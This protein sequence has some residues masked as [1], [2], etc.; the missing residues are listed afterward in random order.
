[1]VSGEWCD[2]DAA[3]DAA[4]QAL[5]D[6]GIDGRGAAP[7][8]LGELLGAERLRGAAE[9]LEGGGLRGRQ[10]DRVGACDERHRFE[11]VDVAGTGLILG[12]GG[13]DGLVTPTIRLPLRAGITRATLCELAHGIG[14][15]VE[16]GVFALDRLLGSDEVFLSS[17]VR[18]VMPVIAVDG[19]EVARGPAAAALQRALRAAAGYPESA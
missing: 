7:G 1:M 19:V 18:E 2:V 6:E 4:G 5:V 8:E 14:Y 10:R 16:E 12:S 17:S 9:M 3:R 13:D 15:E 11:H